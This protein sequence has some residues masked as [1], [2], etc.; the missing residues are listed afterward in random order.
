MKQLW[1]VMG[2]LITLLGT[3][4]MAQEKGNIYIDVGEAKA[5]KSLLALPPFQ[6]YGS[7]SGDKNAIKY[8]QEM[9]ATVKNDLLMSS[10]F[11]FIDTKAFLEDTTKTGLKPAPQQP[12][13]FSFSKWTPLG[14]EFLIR[15]GYKIIDDKID[16]EAYLYY[17]PQAKLIFGKSYAGPPSVLRKL[18]HT[19]TNDVVQALTGKKGFFN[20]KFVLSSNRDGNYKEIYTMDWDGKNLRRIT[21]FKT[22]SISPA[23]SHDGNKIAFTSFAYHPKAKTR[24]AD[25]FSYDFKTGKTLLLSH[26]KGINSGANFHPKGKYLYFTLSKR[27]SPDIFRF[28]LASE[29]LLPITNGPTR[30]MNVE[31][32]VSPD[33]SQ[34][35]FSSDRSGNPM[36]YVMPIA[37][38][39]AKRITLAGKY[40]ASP[41]WS[42]DGKYIAFAGYDKSHF[43][44]F[45]MKPD[46]TEL[47]RLTSA[48]KPSGKWANNEA[49]SWSPDGRRI[50]FTS[51]RSG[52]NQVYIINPDGSDERRITFDRYNYEKPKWSPYLED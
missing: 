43:D 21:E 30:A 19:M 32:D 36:I 15:A 12:N 31:P 38:G 48:K 2:L 27:G 18:A 8:G 28:D 44:I 11:T 34:I 3:S 51:N 22:I 47:K 13:G 5:K 25:L 26:R 6:Y 40:N 46:G 16:L 10:L 49:P 9:F 41:S 29:A 52:T 7:A 45:T 20:T 37:G 35:A 39:K 50:V 4:S 33:G 1:I 42:P 23:W 14:T 24:N 17:V